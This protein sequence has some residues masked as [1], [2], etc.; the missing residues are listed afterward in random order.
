MLTSFILAATHISSA[1]LLAVI[2]NTLVT[3]T[4]VGAGRA[5]AL[6]YTSRILLAAIGVWLVIRAL[7]R[8]PHV[9]GEGMAV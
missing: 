6:E 1:V 8:R 2:T 3:R 9:H 7:R 5:P 4:L